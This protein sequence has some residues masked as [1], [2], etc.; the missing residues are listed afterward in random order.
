MGAKDP[1]VRVRGDAVVFRMAGAQDAAGWREHHPPAM[2]DFTREEFEHN[3]GIFNQIKI[4][5]SEAMGSLFGNHAEGEAAAK[6]VNELLASV[7][8][9]TPRPRMPWE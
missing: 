7:L 4:G 1:S 3:Y 2:V 6:K 9:G 8:N 5:D